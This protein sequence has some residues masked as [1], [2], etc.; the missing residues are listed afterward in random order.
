VKL[1]HPG[2]PIDRA[3]RIPPVPTTP[4]AAVEGHAELRVGRKG[5]LL[6][7]SGH[8][9]SQGVHLQTPPVVLSAFQ[10]AD[11]FTPATAIR[12]SGM[13][14]RC[15]LVA[16]FGTGIGPG[17]A[18]GVHGQLLSTADPLVGEWTVTVV[19]PHYSGALIA[20]DLGDDGPDLDR[21]YEFYVTHDRDLVLSAARS[22]MSRITG[23]RPAGT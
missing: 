23:D 3:R 19:G 12:Y 20:R 2:S 21:R 11:R 17:A 13:A 8:I 22:L 15:P 9:E 4:F 1:P 5:L 6:G 14:A 10:T 18:P 16:A 7:L